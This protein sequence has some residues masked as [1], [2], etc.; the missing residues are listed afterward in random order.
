MIKILFFLLICICSALLSISQTGSL[1]VDK[2]DSLQI[3]KV[4]KS[5]TIPKQK[6]ADDIIKKIGESLD[7]D[8]SDNTEIGSFHLNR[9][10]LVFE[11]GFPI[12]NLEQIFQ[13]NQKIDKMNDSLKGKNELVEQVLVTFKE[14][15]ISDGKKVFATNGK[16]Y[17]NVVYID[18][19]TLALS[20]GV[21][22]H[23][24]V[25]TSDGNT[26]LNAKAPIPILTLAKRFEDK[27]YNPKNNNFILLKDALYFRSPRRFNYFPNAQEITIVNE[28]DSSS[29]KLGVKKL[30]A[31]NNL[32]AMV[33]LQVYSDLLGVFANQPNGLIQFEA[34]TKLYL[35]RG[36]F[37]NS[38]VYAPADAIE[39]FF[40]FSRIDSKFDSIPVDTI[41]NKLNR[42]ELFRR[43]T[44]AVGLDINIFRADWQPSNSF[45]LKAG[46]MYTSSNLIVNEKKMPIALHTPYFE[47]VVKSKKLNNFGIDLRGRIMFQKLNKNTYS[48]DEHTW[49]EMLSFRA[50][51][52]YFPN[53]KQ[54][55]K[56][57]LRFINYLNLSDRKQ[58]F[59]QLQLGFSKAISFNN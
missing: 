35:H 54:A 56:I 49:N 25:Y 11:P 17:F 44:Y 20:E 31:E 22:E 48:N 59:A 8:K 41:T 19:V 2:V 30:Y 5:D 57:F 32:N 43:Y 27:L 47:L 4:N 34:N 14:D 55:D 50:N 13:I 29:V 1:T 28:K 33:N 52:F 40:H 51:I 37:R 58:D 42:I 16:Y 6:A 26:Y 15:T 39:P 53:K 23:I 38:F 24:L 3:V 10:A 21:I 12:G 18:S 36:N 45:E 7:K 46:Y 9:H